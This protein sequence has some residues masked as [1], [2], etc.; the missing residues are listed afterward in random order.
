MTL[1]NITEVG[2]A[3]RDLEKTTQMLVD[4]L[5]GEAGQV[6]DVPAFGMRFRMV[7]LGNVDL[8]LM[9]PTDPDGMIAKFIQTKGEGLHHIAF[10]VDDIGESIMRLK[11]KGCKLV[12]EKPLE[13]LGGKVVFLHPKSF[14]GIAIELIEYPEDWKGWT[15]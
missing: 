10:A 7:R 14:S 4:I 11:E 6:L 12:N 8:E 13:I 1:K 5:G 2:V 3:V 15:K 9:E